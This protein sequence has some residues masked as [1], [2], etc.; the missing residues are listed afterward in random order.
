MQE[1]ESI[2]NNLERQKVNGLAALSKEA[3][4]VEKWWLTCG[5]WTAAGTLR[6]VFLDCFAR[7]CR[8]SSVTQPLSICTQSLLQTKHADLSSNKNK[9]E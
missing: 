5:D 3:E 7:T 1:K 8:G 6:Q 4:T 9:K 2:L